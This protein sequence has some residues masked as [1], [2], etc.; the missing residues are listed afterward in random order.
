MHGNVGPVFQ[1]RMFKL[2]YEQSFPTLC[3]KGFLQQV[4]PRGG[5]PDQFGRQVMMRQTEPSRDLLGLPQG[6]CAVTGGD[7]N[8]HRVLR[9]PLG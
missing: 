3:C 9:V 8:M 2:L 1:Q 7:S 6:E 5:H 4:I